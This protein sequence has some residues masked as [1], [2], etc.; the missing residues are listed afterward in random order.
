MK[1]LELESQGSPKVLDNSKISAFELCPRLYFLRYELHLTQPTVSPAL[2]FGKAFHRGVEAF[3]LS[4]GNMEA[5]QGAALA[6]LEA[7]LEGKEA[8][9]DYRLDPSNL[10]LAL[11]YYIAQGLPEIRGLARSIEC[12]VSLA[13]PAKEDPEW[14]FGGR[15][16][17]VLE[18]YA[19]ELIVIDLKTTSWSLNSG[20]WSSK[21]LTD[22]QLQ[23]YAW[24]LEATKQR[25]VAA[26][27]YSILYIY[28]R[29]RKDG[30]YSSP[31]LET[32]FLPVALTE[33]HKERAKWR[34]VNALQGIKASSFP[35][36][37]SACQ[38]W[39]RVCQFHPLCE[40]FWNEDPRENSS[41]ILEIAQA[42][43]YIQEEWNPL[44]PE[45]PKEGG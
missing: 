10:S 34:A 2:A 22:V 19:G 36:N 5:A 9:L 31:N 30:S 16:D 29:A 35:C 11:S 45:A 21:L 33:S 37:F 27:A 24:L 39:N 12:E 8:P 41:A 23:M 18:N 17:L 25:R 1:P 42:L 7:E 6:A 3:L 15:A 40:R 44:E 13:L 4:G 43:G 14:V 26:G 20:G 38:Q 28:A 32:S